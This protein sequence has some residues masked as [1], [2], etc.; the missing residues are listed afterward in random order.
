MNI[1]IVNNQVANKL[2]IKES[3]VAAINK[4]FWQKVYHHFYDYNS[5]PINI[6]NVCVI[7]PTAY[8]TKKQILYYVDGIRRLQYNKRYKPNSQ[9]RLNRIEQFKDNL[10]KVWRIRK[11]NQWIN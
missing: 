2:K 4:F 6:P 3:E 7:Y 11:Q 9:M 8:H 5:Q 10:R 1:D